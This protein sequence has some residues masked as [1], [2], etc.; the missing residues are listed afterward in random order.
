[1]LVRS[2]SAAVR[3]DRFGGFIDT[4]A[5]S[6]EGQL[7]RAQAV[8][9]DQARI[10]RDLLA[11]CQ[12]QNIAGDDLRRIDGLVGAIAQDGGLEHQQ[13]VQGFQLLLGTILLEEAQGNAQDDNA[14]N[15]VGCQPATAFPREVADRKGQDGCKEQHE[16]EIIDKLLEQ[17]APG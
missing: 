4:D 5:F 2:A 6:G 16:N 11:L 10:H 3:C 13:P 15:E 17:Q 7:V 8:S 1:M 9:L 14:K 12:H